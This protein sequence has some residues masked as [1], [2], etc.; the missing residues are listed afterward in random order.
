MFLLFAY[1]HLSPDTCINISLLQAGSF[2]P[3]FRAHAHIDTKRREP[4]LLPEENMKIVRE[5][6]RKRYTYLPFW[7]TLFY[8]GFRSGETVMSPLWV[9]YP[10]DKSTFEMDD[11][12]LLGKTKVFRW[13]DLF[14]KASDEIIY[15]LPCYCNYYFLCLGS[16]LLVKPITEQGSVGTSVYFPGKDEV[17]FRINTECFSKHV[18]LVD[19]KFIPFYFTYMI[20]V[21]T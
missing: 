19:R 10:E 13:K 12:Y 14:T 4:F 11:E 21:S 15:N 16:S 7:Y 18:Y 1:Q 2:Q 8:H 9:T 3:F 5:A 17:S 6:I 20:H